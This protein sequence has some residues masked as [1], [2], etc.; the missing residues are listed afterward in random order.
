MFL[1]Y[2]DVM[3]SKIFFLKIQNIILIQF[4]TKKKYF[5]TPDIVKNMRRGQTV[6]VQCLDSN[7]SKMRQ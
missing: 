6:T 7:S 4:Q 1:N 2:F 3:I 5:K